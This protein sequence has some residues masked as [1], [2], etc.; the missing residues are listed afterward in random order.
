MTTPV[1]FLDDASRFLGDVERVHAEEAAFTLLATLRKLKK[2]NGKIALNTVQSIGKYQIS[3]NWS[4]QIIL[5]GNS[6]REEWDFI[7]ALNDRSPF[8]A[9]M[10]EGL[11]DEVR[12]MEFRTKPGMV[13]SSAL[14]WAALLDSATV[15]FDAHSDW[16]KS[17]VESAYIE[18]DINGDVHETDISI[19]NA[20]KV[21]HAEEHFEW[22]TTIG[23]IAVETAAQVW[24]EKT[25]QFPGLRFLPRVEK[26]LTELECSGIPFQQAIAALKCLVNDVKNWKID[27]PWPDF[28]TKASPEAQ[29]RQNFCY[30]VDDVT[31]KSELFH[32]H[33][34]FTGGIAG[35][36]HFRVD[37]TN[38]QIV[39]AYIG[40]KLNKAISA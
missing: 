19:R 38:R 32:W 4:L 15:S 33:T 25:D 27:C 40:G 11:L 21:E 6:C 8:A 14:A 12:G 9:G 22:L 26:D 3:D 7:R 35:R 20:S 10:E 16:K 30:V 28:S 39:V 37:G 23:Q 36:V 17:W 1:I 18:L 13:Q 5:G 34:R 24:A 31:N 29:Q 2:I